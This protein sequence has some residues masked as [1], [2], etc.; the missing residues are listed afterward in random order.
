MATGVGEVRSD[1]DCREEKGEIE[2]KSE[3]QVDMVDTVTKSKS[4]EDG[5]D[6]DNIDTVESSSL[7]WGGGVRLNAILHR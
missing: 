3:S 1:G 6:V 7:K 2:R 5:G 4:C